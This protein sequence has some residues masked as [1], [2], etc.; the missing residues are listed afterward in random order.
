[1]SNFKPSRECE[2]CGSADGRCRENLDQPGSGLCMSLVGSVKGT[3]INGKIITGHTKDDR[4]AIFAPDNS[5]QWTEE[6]R[7]E[8][9]DEQRRR[10]EQSERE[11]RQK[12]AQLLP[13]PE[14]D[15]QYRRIVASL[16][17]NQKHRF[18]ELSE[19]R[20]LNAEEIDFAVSQ[21]WLC[22]WQR[23]RLIS[24]LSPLLAGV[25][26]GEQGTTL[27]GVQGVGIAAINST[28]SI[29][30]FQIASDNREK[31]GKYL[32]LSSASK[33]GNGPHLPSGELPIFVWRHPE[34]KEV[35]ETWLVEGGL[36]SLITALKLWFR[37][38]RKDIQV[39]GAAG[40]NFKGSISAVLE[41]L[42]GKVVLCPD[43]GSLNNASILRQYTSIIEILTSK[44]YSASVAWWDQYVKKQN[45]DVDELE[46]EDLLK[47]KFISTDEFK[48]KGDKVQS[49]IKKLDKLKAEP[50][51]KQAKEESN[52]IDWAFENWKKDRKFTPDIVVNQKYLNLT[53]IPDSG[54]IIAINSWLG[55]GKSQWFL[56]YV[57]NS[58]RG[59]IVTG[60]VNSILIQIVERGCEIGLNIY[61]LQSN[62]GGYMMIPDENSKIAICP[63][64]LHH[65]DGYFKG[66]NIIIDEA[67]S[68][69][70]G[71]AEG[72][73]LKERQAYIIAVFN[74][75]I[76]EANNVFLLDGNLRDLDVDFV[77]KLSKG[78]KKSLKIFNEYKSKPQTFKFLDVMSIEEEGKEA[79]VKKHD[80]SP[81]T[82]YWC[83]EQVKPWIFSDSREYLERQ[84]RILKQHNKKG[85]VLHRLTSGEDWAKKECLKKPDEF[86]LAQKLDYFG[87]T[88]T[89]NTGFSV[90]VEHL[91]TDK[92]SI[93]RGVLGINEAV[94]G[95]HRLRDR[96]H[97]L[98]HFVMCP[99]KSTIKNQNIPHHYNTQAFMKAVQEAYSL[100]AHLAASATDDPDI[101]LNM[102]FEAIK[103][104]DPD[105]FHYANK[106]YSIDNYER[107]NYRKCLVH[108]L[109]QRGNKIEFI[110][111]NT[112]EAYAKIEKETK[113]ELIDEAATREY[114]AVPYD[115]LDAAKEAA[116]GKVDADVQAR[117]S[118]TYLLDKLPG[119]RDKDVWS[120]DFIKDKV[121]K[122]KH[123]I[124]ENERFYLLKNIEIA[125]KR[126]EAEWYYLATN[127]YYFT[128]ISK[129]RS[130][131]LL[132][133]LQELKILERFVNSQKE[134]HK[135]SPEVIELWNE[136][137]SRK[138][139]QIALRI[140]NLTKKTDGQER[141]ALVSKLLGMIGVD[142]E[143][144]GRKV[145]EEGIRQRHYTINQDKFNAPERLAVLECLEAKFDKWLKSDAVSKIKWGI[146]KPQPQIQPEVNNV[147]EL[148]TETIPTIHELHTA[149]EPEIITTQLQIEVPQPQEQLVYVRRF[150]YSESFKSKFRII[151]WID[152]ETVKIQSTLT[153]EYFT[154]N[155][156]DLSVA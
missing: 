61:H 114:K 63:D 21:N 2:G 83:D 80:C 25:V 72:G 9:V 103:R 81:V 143:S 113:E 69:L 156:L 56:N 26:R 121:L 124:S 39:I 19:R 70:K 44:A 20:G 4:W 120:K 97:N 88:P 154:E 36:K 47:L 65:L 14:R 29:T 84:D 68:V 152:D 38:G 5:E 144:A 106:L 127:E 119:I 76:Q 46:A 107:D 35:T 101:A 95:M 145:T 78:T 140:D 82:E 16:G 116:K 93:L 48:V 42:Q 96:G 30:G 146:E 133:G 64:S 135:D 94:Q 17:L 147:S 37:C 75:M 131:S 77:V 62:D 52:V 10:R 59:A 98:P 13:I 111:W 125:K 73:T 150:N 79:K 18:S 85:L 45:P 51:G 128:A 6:R 12:L 1:M 141:T 74:K 31:F 7:R 155:R 132:W 129:G 134:W 137:E 34:A 89:A 148:Q 115:T 28:G 105:W 32:W 15:P 53:N 24:G 104:Q 123:F 67:C 102:I 86:F 22:S 130:H 41:A 108:V 109:E 122:D 50:E 142:I 49:S 71:M 87:H 91:F 43:A 55:T 40:A 60:N 110:E 153:G 99:E 136:L 151:E 100:E 23:G 139:V 3:K 57:K 58:D 149:A 138:D 117:I 54:H 92:F 11:K 112:S 33:N 66:K 27:A 90:T 126:H 8:W 118:L